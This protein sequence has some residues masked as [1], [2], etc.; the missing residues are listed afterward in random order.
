MKISTIND[1]ISIIANIGVIASIVFLGLEMR[2]NSSMMKSQTRNEMTQN[3]METQLAV[4]ENSDY[5]KIHNALRADPNAF[6]VVSPEALQALFWNITQLR[7]WENEWYQYQN[8]LFDET[9]FEPRLNLWR[10]SMSNPYNIVVWK[11]AR[12][13]YSPD[14]RELLDSLIQEPTLSPMP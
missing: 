12:L 5:A 2:Q 3:Q 11:Q 7:M 10:N 4:V 8:G 14:F 1:V 6:P 9:E 13:D